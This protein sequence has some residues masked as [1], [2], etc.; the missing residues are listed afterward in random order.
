[1][2][3]PTSLD[4]EVYSFLVVSAGR[5][6]LVTSVICLAII[7]GLAYRWRN[8]SPRMLLSIWG[9]MV[10][11]LLLPLY[12]VMGA[13]SFIQVP[14]QWSYWL[15]TH[16]GWLVDTHPCAKPIRDRISH[17]FSAQLPLLTWHAALVAVWA[18]GALLEFACLIRSRHKFNVIIK[19]A[20]PLREPHIRQKT[21]EWRRR[22][23]IRRQ[24]RLRHSNEF[25]HVFTIGICRPVVFL[26]TTAVEQLS[27][28]EIN[29]VLGHELAHVRRFDDLGIWVIGLLQVI[30]FFTP[31]TWIA[32]RAIAGLREQCCDALTISAGGLSPRQYLLSLLKVIEIQGS[33]PVPRGLM[34]FSP[35]ASSLRHRIAKLMAGPARRNHVHFLIALTAVLCAIVLTGPV[36]SASLDAAGARAL[37]G[38]MHLQ[39]PLP[40]G[41]QRRAFDGNALYCSLHSHSASPHSGIDLYFGDDDRV[42]AALD[43]VVVTVMNDGAAQAGHS[44]YIRA[45]NGITAVYMHLGRPSVQPGDTVHAG[46]M[47]AGRDRNLRYDYM[48]FELTYRGLSFN[49]ALLDANWSAPANHHAL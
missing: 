19:H 21:E 32:N 49:P 12:S 46:Q 36:S 10:L 26:P 38:E 4:W 27:G 18:A 28:D 35:M 31:L 20:L 23:R 6:L 1:M 29:A 13:V 22:Y 48:H 47:I 5:Q 42:L 37:F 16:A 15:M 40:N 41:A 9:L 24:V 2:I 44:V 11:P 30:F 14:A 33:R 45:A 8:G 3:L 34:M 25:T 17:S 39:S 43:G 7:L